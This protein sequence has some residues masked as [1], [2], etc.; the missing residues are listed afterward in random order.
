MGSNIDVIMFAG[1]KRSGKDYTAN[2]FQKLQVLDSSAIAE[3]FAFAEPMKQAVC[4]LFDITQEQLETYKNNEED[5]GIEL[6][7]Y[8]NNQPSATISYLSFRQILQRFGTEAIKPIFGD[9]IWARHI[10]KSIIDS[11][12]NM[13]IITDFRFKEEYDTIVDVFGKEHVFT[14]NVISKDT[15]LQG[16]S[17][18]S[19]NA[20][21]GFEFNYNFYNTR[22]ENE[23]YH[24]LLKLAVAQERYA[25]RK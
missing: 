24:R 13:A 11:E 21:F 8:P 4:A 25:C 3:K 12:C 1:K 6:K 7:A 15:E 22:D 20:L 5:Y 23:Y 18:S 14:V 2:A 10:A 9:D 17:H 16:D 19:E